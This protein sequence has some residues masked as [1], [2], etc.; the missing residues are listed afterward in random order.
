MELSELK[1]AWKKV[2]D[3]SA[4][5]NRLEENQLRE[6]LSNRG[7]G[8]ISRLDRNVKIGFG[9]L[10]LFILLTFIDELLPNSFL[11]NGIF[12][13]MPQPPLWLLASSWIVNIFI[14]FT[15]ISFAWKYYRLRVPHLTA[16]QLT[17]ALNKLLIVL[18]TFKKQFYLALFLFIF[19][20]GLSFSIGMYYGYTSVSKTLGQ[21]SGQSFWLIALVVV[22]MLIILGIFVTIITSI[23]HLGFKN[24]YGKYHQQLKDTLHE[25][26][27]L[28]D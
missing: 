24:L 2:A 27:E 16:E 5:G 4:D 1:T 15:F 7:K 25:L 17:T 9:L 6:I 18:D 14:A 22:I 21:S 26:N 10:A 8:I 20:A 13:A 19:E 11:N 28:E 12:E 23:F 3:R